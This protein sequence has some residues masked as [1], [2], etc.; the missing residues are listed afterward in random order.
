MLERTRLE[1]RLNSRPTYGRPHAP[2]VGTPPPMRCTVPEPKRQIAGIIASGAILLLMAAGAA[3]MRGASWLPANVCLSCDDLPSLT[4]AAESP[5][6]VAANS[7][8]AHSEHMTGAVHESEHHDDDGDV[9]LAPVSFEARG[10]GGNAGDGGQSGDRDF[11]SHGSTP[12]IRGA[13]NDGHEHG[14]RSGGGGGNVGMSGG[15]SSTHVAPASEHAAATPAA[16]KPA[17]AAAPAAPSRPSAPPAAGGAP[18]TAPKPPPLAAPPAIPAAVGGS[19]VAIPIAPVAGPL[20]DDP[21][22]PPA[23]PGAFAAPTIAAVTASPTPEPASLFLL[24][25]GI[26][27]VWTA[28]RRRR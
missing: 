11:T 9:A 13:A 25:T 7:P 15:G 18:A 19:A 8:A 3:A 20:A 12:L 22:L 23:G 1:I 6:T 5:R 27:G 2:L 21:F 16:D 24:G 28:A 26:L 10:S 14:P 17:P 4:A